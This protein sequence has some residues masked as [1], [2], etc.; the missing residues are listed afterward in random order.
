MI[1]DKNNGIGDLIIADTFWTKKSTHIVF[2]RPLKVEGDDSMDLKIEGDYKFYLQ[3]G[4]FDSE[5]DEDD[6]KLKGNI[7]MDNYE[8][9]TIVPISNAKRMG[10]MFKFASVG[11]LVLQ[12]L[13]IYS[14]VG[15]INVIIIKLLTNNK[16]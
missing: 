5:D 6:S 3:W 13:S 16:K 8:S 9:I 11:L 15:K 4:L 2:R 14:W 10:A 12:V 7:F 1:E